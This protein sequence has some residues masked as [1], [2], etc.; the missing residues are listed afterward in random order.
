M[1]VL[2]VDPRQKIL[3]LTSKPLLMADD[4]NILKAY[5]DISLES[6]YYGTIVQENKF[7]FIVSFFNNVKGFLTFKDIEEANNISRKNF[8]IGQTVKVFVGFVKVQ[9]KK[10]WLSLTLK[11]AKILNKMMLTGQQNA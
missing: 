2:V 1:R 9:Q 3:K 10:I 8:K 7:G 4:L 5:D 6:E 11:T